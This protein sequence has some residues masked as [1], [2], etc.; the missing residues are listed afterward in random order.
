MA[1]LTELGATLAALPLSSALRASAWAY[2]LV[3]IVHLAGMAL[4][5]GTIA[6]VDL[7]LAGLWRN[8]PVTALLR[9]VL[10]LTMAAFVAVAIS[11]VLLLLAHADELATNPALYAKLALI[12]LGLLNAL[13][14]HLW[15]YRALQR[16]AGPGEARSGAA[17]AD[18]NVGVRPPRAAR[19]AAVLSLLTW[20]LVIAAGR[21]IAYV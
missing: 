7:R 14:F 19:T 21:L 15:P 17:V 11:G 16:A 10:P 20:T 1:S 8:L 5:F 18:W 13:A 6:V 3:E 4:L 2:P 9:Q 12:A